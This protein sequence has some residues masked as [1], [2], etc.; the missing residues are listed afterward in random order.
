MHGIWESSALSNPMNGSSE[1]SMFLT[2][3]PDGTIGHMWAI[4]YS[5]SILGDELVV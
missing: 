2:V 5:Y 4:L 3:M 1:I